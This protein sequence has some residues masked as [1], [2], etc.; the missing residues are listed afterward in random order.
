VV[1]VFG[2]QV[3]SWRTADGLERLYLSPLA[4][5]DGRTAIRG[6][7]PVCF[8][9]FGRQ[10]P[11]TPHGFAR[12]QRWNLAPADPALPA[13][14]TFRLHDNAAT[15]T[16]WPYA[17]DATLSI[18]LA[19]RQLQ[20]MLS[21]HNAGPDAFDFTAALHTYLRV[22]DLAVARLDGLLD[23]LVLT[24]G[25][26]RILA[27]APERIDLVHAGG[28][29]VVRQGGGFGDTVVWNPGSA[30]IADVPGCD[31]TRFLCVEA[32]C[33]AHPARLAAADV[34]SGWQCL[35]VRD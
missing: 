34:W 30:L 4:A 13:T 11:L 16:E 31:R 24:G 20:V 23:P 27:A 1:S 33:V 18:A 21:V 9:Q 15:R 17:F 26:D 5:F 8:P 28:G 25:I 12:R 6:G 10:G 35:T 14:L 7:V 19:P 29:L 2:A 22:D 3:L 32:A